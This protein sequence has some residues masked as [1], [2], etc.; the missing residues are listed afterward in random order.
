MFF[1]MYL[2]EINDDNDDSISCSIEHSENITQMHAQHGPEE[3]QT[4][5]HTTGKFQFCNQEKWY[6]N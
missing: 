1:V 5:N 3:A 2:L 6:I 4:F